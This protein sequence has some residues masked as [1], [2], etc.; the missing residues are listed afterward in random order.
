MHLKSVRVQQYLDPC[1]PQKY[2]FKLSLKALHI[3]VI[4][5]III[6]YLF[7]VQDCFAFLP[8]LLKMLVFCP[9]GSDHIYDDVTV[10]KNRAKG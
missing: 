8:F 7:S 9:A 4:F 6:I 10:V 1:I 5:I 3:I 2:I